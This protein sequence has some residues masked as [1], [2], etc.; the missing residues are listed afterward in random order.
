MMGGLVGVAAIVAALY[1]VHAAVHGEARTSAEQSTI[2]TQPSA[3]ASKPT[4]PPL[5][6]LL[7]TVAA[8]KGDYAIAVVDP[9]GRSASVNGGKDYIA[10]ST[11]KLFIAY[12]MFQAVN[13]GSLSWSDEVLGDQTTETCFE[14]MIVRS[15]NNCPE[16]FG[17]LIGWQKIND[18][19]R[20][21]GLHGTQVKWHDNHT[22]ANDLALFLTKLQ[23]G[24]LLDG[25]DSQ[26]LLGYMQQQIYRQGI[27]AGTGVAVA[28][29]VGFLD[30][31]IHDAGIVYGAKGPYVL[32]IMSNNSSWSQLADVAKQV[33]NFI[34]Q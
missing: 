15:D 29:K 13:S 12:G 14:L 33:D 3:T 28:D 22:T 7:D 5:Q 24:T 17:N 11:Y 18:M 6:T 23:A 10:A 27:P 16:A 20:T 21:L 2:A 31:Y 9:A 30:A 1:W 26:K 25:A 19:M 8:A 32:V 34:E 4:T